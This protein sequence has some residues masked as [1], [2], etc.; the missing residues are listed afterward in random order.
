M[1]TLSKHGISQEISGITLEQA[2]EIFISMDNIS[3][4]YKDAMTFIDAMKKYHRK[5]KFELSPARNPQLIK[6]QKK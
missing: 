3:I 1:K 6:L 4:P 2:M 5:I